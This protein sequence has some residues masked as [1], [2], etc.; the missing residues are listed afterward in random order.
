[1]SL[2]SFITVINGFLEIST[3]PSHFDP[4][5]CLLNLTKISDPAPSFYFDPPPPPFIRHLKV[6]V[7]V[8]CKYHDWFGSYD[9]FFYKGFTKN[10]EIKN[11]P[12]WALLNIWRLGQ[13]RDTKFDIN[14]SNVMLLNAAKIPGLQL[15]LFL[16]N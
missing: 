16:S 5:P 14:V 8:S 7:Q 13:V 1:M 10:P 4:P 3:P 11:T 12:V 6:L 2:F 15:L 9:N